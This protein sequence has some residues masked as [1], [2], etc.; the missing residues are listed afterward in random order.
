M[1]EVIENILCFLIAAS[2]VIQLAPDE[3]YKKCMKLFI[4]IVFLVV[5]ISTLFNE[6]ES[7]VKIDIF[8][9]IP[10]ISESDTE[11]YENIFN[12]YYGNVGNEEN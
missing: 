11:Y 1:A 2:I 7:I 4:G 8:E 9:H 5:V 12:D 6:V 3:S 10:D